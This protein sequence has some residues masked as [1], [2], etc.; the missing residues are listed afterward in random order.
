MDFLLLLALLGWIVVAFFI[1]CGF[2]RIARRMRH[3]D[4]RQNLVPTLRPALRPR[5]G[6]LASAG[7]AGDLRGVR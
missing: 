1:A 6:G 2:G 5:A 4:P 7:R 3:D